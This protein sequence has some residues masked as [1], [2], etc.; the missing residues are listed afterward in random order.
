VKEIVLLDNTEGGRRPNFL[1]HL[2]Q[3]RL[4]KMYQAQELDITDSDVV[5]M[6]LMSEV[7]EEE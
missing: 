6:W 3:E 7:Q 4:T 5:G 1:Q 2:K